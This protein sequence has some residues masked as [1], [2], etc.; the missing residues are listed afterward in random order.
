MFYRDVIQSN[1]ACFTSGRP[2]GI[3]PIAIHWWGDPGNHP[4]FEGVINTFTGDARG[5]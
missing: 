5:A 1:S 3:T 4:T 2:Y